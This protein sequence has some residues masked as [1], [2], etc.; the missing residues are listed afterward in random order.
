MKW[1][2][3]HYILLMITKL[4]FLYGFFD[5]K[6]FEVIQKLGDE[7]IVSS[8]NKACVRDWAVVQTV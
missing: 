4:T 5:T 6:N 3:I 7:G 8:I 2:E 1:I